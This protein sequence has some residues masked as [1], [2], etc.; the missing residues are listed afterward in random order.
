M[1]ALTL[2]ATGEAIPEP[3]GKRDGGCDSPREAG[4]FLKTG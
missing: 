3:A 1:A 4:D 2:A